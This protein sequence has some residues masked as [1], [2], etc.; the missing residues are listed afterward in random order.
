[1]KSLFYPQRSMSGASFN[2]PLCPNA[3]NSSIITITSEQKTETKINKN[4]KDNMKVIP[5]AVVILFIIVLFCGVSLYR[6][7]QRDKGN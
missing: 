4:F 2:L 1:M 3:Q 5:I 6:R 7:T